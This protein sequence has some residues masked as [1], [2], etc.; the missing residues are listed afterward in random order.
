VTGGIS[1]YPVWTGIGAVGTT[2]LGIL[3]LSE[4]AN[5]IWIVSIILIVGGIA[6]LKLAE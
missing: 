3:I 2:L 1:F 5:P 4:S 6:G